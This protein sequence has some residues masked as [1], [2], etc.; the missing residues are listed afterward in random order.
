MTRRHLLRQASLLTGG[1]LLAPAALTA[2]LQSCADTDR[3]AWQPTYFTPEEADFLTAYVDTLLPRTDTPGGLDVKVDVFIDRVLTA[4]SAPGETESPV[5][6]GIRAFEEEVRTGGGTTFAALDAGGRGALFAAAEERSPRYNPQVWGTAVGEEPPIDFYRS[7]KS[8]ALWAYL[9]SEE[10][11][12]EV[13]NYDPVPGGFDGDIP[14]A[15][16]GGRAWS[17]G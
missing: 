13:L 14:L 16:V 11:G 4:T 17:L 15:S 1:T 6:D 3:R 9:S 2:L 12:T 7:L 5:R 10:I 8:M